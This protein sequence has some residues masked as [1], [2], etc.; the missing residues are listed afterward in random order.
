MVL[1]PWSIIEGTFSDADH[2]ARD[3]DVGQA[4]AITEGRVADVGH[5]VADCDGGQTAATIESI[6][7]YGINI[8]F[9]YLLSHLA[10]EYGL[11]R[12]E[13]TPVC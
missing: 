4:S 5:T 10:S 13:G 12:G 1:V 9:D 2:A 3:G 8:I 11:H 7:T 6:R